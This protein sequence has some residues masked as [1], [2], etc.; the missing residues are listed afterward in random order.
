MLFLIK[1]GVRTTELPAISD[2]EI[3]SS[4]ISTSGSVNDKPKNN[5]VEP[6]VGYVTNDLTTACTVMDF[7]TNYS[8]GNGVAFVAFN[9]SDSMVEFYRKH[10]ESM[11][12]GLEFKKGK[13]QGLAYT[14]RVDP[15][16]MPSPETKLTGKVMIALNEWTK[17]VGIK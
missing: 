9:S 5:S 16:S 17:T 12:V 7:V 3:P 8:A 14:I 13:K 10:S 15:R 11:K 1:L 6:T 2:G 4:V